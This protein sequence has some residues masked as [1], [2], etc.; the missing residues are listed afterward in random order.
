LN[1]ESAQILLLCFSFLLL[2]AI[3]TWKN[4]GIKGFYRGVGISAVQTN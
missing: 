4:E 2:L 3:E 1:E